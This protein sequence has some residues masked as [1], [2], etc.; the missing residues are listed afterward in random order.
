[1]KDKKKFGGISTKPKNR[2][3]KKF[4]YGDGKENRKYWRIEIKRMY[5]KL[6]KHLPI[7][8]EEI[9]TIW[10]NPYFNSEDMF[11][12][13]YN[14]DGEDYFNKWIKQVFDKLNNK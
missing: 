2:N 14:W 10:S 1:M 4:G 6:L 7:N 3:C 5:H 11:G 9:K 13:T 12:I 8:V